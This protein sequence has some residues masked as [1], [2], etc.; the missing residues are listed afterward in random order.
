MS[1]R[2]AAPS[3]APAVVVPAARPLALVLLTLACS[4]PP[5]KPAAQVRVVNHAQLESELT[6]RRGRPLVIN[7]WAMWCAPCVAELPDLLASWHEVRAKGVELVLISYDLMMPDSPPA[8]V[9]PR[10]QEFLARRGIDA[11]VLLYDALDYDA[12]NK[13][14]GLQGGVPATLVLDQNGTIVERHE[15]AAERARFD[16]LMRKAAGG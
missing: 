16:A 13:R 9:L 2:G 14:L 8:K 6:A 1:N 10:L 11:T 3:S 4:A 7:L 5:P 15:E 12:I